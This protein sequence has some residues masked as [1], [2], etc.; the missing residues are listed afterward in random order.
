MLRHIP[1]KNSSYSSNYRLRPRNSPQGL[2]PNKFRIQKS[3]SKNSFSSNLIS[4]HQDSIFKIQKCE[5]SN[6]KFSFPS[7]LIKEKSQSLL[8]NNSLSPKPYLKLPIL[9]IFN[10]KIES[11]QEITII[12]SQRKNS[13]GSA[14][15]KT[16]M[17]TIGTST[18]DETEPREFCDKIS[19]KSKANM[20]KKIFLK[21][22]D[23]TNILDTRPYSKTPDSH[24]IHE[25]LY[26]KR[27]R[28]IKDLRK[29]NFPI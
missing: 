28:L 2:K 8:K 9:S 10:K 21:G 20:Q 23:L 25:N 12:S 4:I 29:N 22:K 14:E 7:S 11:P 16:N 5:I 15:D 27:I 19:L 18:N 1:Q 24:L 13:V 6:P 17:C 26:I 3:H